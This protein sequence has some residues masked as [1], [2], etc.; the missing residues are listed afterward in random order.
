MMNESGYSQF[1][2]RTVT[3][4]ERIICPIIDSSTARDVNREKELRR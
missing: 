3:S 4:T 2:K 1:K